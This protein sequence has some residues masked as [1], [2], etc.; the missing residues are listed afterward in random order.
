MAHPLS[1]KAQVRQKHLR[2]R[3]LLHQSQRLYQLPRLHRLPKLRQLQK[4]HQLRGPHRRLKLCQ[5]RQFFNLRNSLS[6][7]PSNN[8]PNNTLN[9]LNNTPSLL[10]NI[11]NLLLLLYRWRLLL[12]HQVEIV[13]EQAPPVLLQILMTYT[14]LPWSKIFRG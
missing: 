14:P 10:N 6:S 8:P 11:F 12:L 3:Q 5:P 7:S 4:P 2:R 13:K 9:P 1:I